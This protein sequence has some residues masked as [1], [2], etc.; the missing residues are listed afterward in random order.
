MRRDTTIMLHALP[1]VWFR[2]Q[3][4]ADMSKEL[5]YP[6]AT[7]L[8]PRAIRPKSPLWCNEGMS[9]ELPGPAKRGR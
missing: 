7:P 9:P 6:T 4:N 3:S 2:T 1:Y 5:E 8:P